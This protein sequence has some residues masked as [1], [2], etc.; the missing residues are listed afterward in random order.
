MD[1]AT[2]QFTYRKAQ[3]LSPTVL[4]GIITF[5]DTM[6]SAEYLP[7]ITDILIY[8]SKNYQNIFGQRFKVIILQD[9]G[10]CIL[11]TIVTL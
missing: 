10:W 5:L 6:D 11:L 4:D 1:S 3:E 7:T 2:D 9:I 8:F